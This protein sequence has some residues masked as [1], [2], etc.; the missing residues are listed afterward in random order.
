MKESTSH[1]SRSRS[2]PLSPT[3]SNE[4]AVKKQNK[5]HSHGRSG[6]TGKST[7]S[8]SP[9][10]TLSGSSSSGSIKHDV[11]VSGDCEVKGVSEEMEN[12]ANSL[13][14]SKEDE[15]GEE[16]RE[17]DGETHVEKDKGEEGE[18]EGGW[19][20]INEP[21]DPLKN[22]PPPALQNESEQSEEN[23]AESENA[24][25]MAEGEEREE[26]EC[27]TTAS[28][29]PSP[30][31]L[32][33]APAPSVAPPPTVPTVAPPPTN[34]HQQSEEEDSSIVQ[35]QLTVLAGCVVAFLADGNLPLV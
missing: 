14:T 21:T 26:K 20:Q 33:A 28:E 30:S 3:H 24:S 12:G 29:D 19:C 15:G 18:G 23:G 35:G 16:E 31:E 25:V 22:E 32:T 6:S 4:Q 17:E 13:N 5:S 34:E 1:H 10:S 9:K 11:D 27:L 2:G 7:P 8:L